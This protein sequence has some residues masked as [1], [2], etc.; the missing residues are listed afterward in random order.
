MIPHEILQD[1]A[2][3]GLAL[4]Q[5]GLVIAVFAQRQILKIHQS[6]L[7]IHMDRLDLYSK[8]LAQ[9]WLEAGLQTGHPVVWPQIEEQE[10][11]H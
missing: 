10:T 3:A 11:K 6:A 8:A 7:R 4:S 9:K 1:I 5:F 2:L